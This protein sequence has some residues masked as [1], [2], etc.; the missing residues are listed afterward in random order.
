MAA[1]AFVKLVAGLP[2]HQDRVRAAAAGA[3]IEVGERTGM[4][5]FVVCLVCFAHVTLASVLCM[6]MLFGLFFD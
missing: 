3:D 5:S 4:N 6:F 2:K 1:A